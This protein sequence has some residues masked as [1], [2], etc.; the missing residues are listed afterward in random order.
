MEAVRLNRLCLFGHIQRIEENRILKR[1]L[2]MNF[3]TT[4]LRGRPRN[5]WQDEVREDGRIVGEGWQEKVHNRE[6]WK[7]L[8][9]T[10]RNSHILHMP[11]EWMNEWI[12]T[13]TLHSMNSMLIHIVNYTRYDVASL[14]VK[15]TWGSRWQCVWNAILC[16]TFPQINFECLSVPLIYGESNLVVESLW[17]ERFILSLYF[18]DKLNKWEIL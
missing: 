17:S 18:G 13:V 7:T 16:H 15:C 9:R 11:M 1:V 14:Y 6:E 2:C 10:A 4:S 5:K 3:G 8:L 12:K